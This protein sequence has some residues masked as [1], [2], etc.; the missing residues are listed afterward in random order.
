MTIAL[1]NTTSRLKTYTLP[2]ESYCKARGRCACAITQRRST[3]RV[4]SSLTLAAEAR[5]EGLDE[6]VLVVPEILRALRAG[7]L[8]LERKPNPA[9]V[10]AKADLNSHRVDPGIR[11]DT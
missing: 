8:R 3:R 7:E 1:I 10:P 11:G 9:A 2:H 4:P 6:A 5:L